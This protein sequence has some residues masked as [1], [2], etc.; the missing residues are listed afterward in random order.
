MN[1][2]TL[3]MLIALIGS[4]VAVYVGLPEQMQALFDDSVEAAHQVG[5]AGDLRSIS[6]M[7]DATYVL[8]RRLP[9]EQEFPAWLRETF[10]ETNVK[11]LAGDHWGNPYVYARSGNGRS[12]RLHSLGPD[13]IMGT[14][15]DMVRSGP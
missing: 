2:F 7:L 4:A 10:K 5:T 6:V 11:E 13:G 3:G 9:S 1:T 8:D 15:D 14:G 12:Y